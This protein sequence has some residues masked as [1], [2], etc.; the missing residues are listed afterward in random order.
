MQ[1][2]TL[3]QIAI[4][5]EP[6]LT[7]LCLALMALAYLKSNVHFL[8]KTE[9]SMK[10]VEDRRFYLRKLNGEIALLKIQ[11]TIMK[12]KRNFLFQKSN[13]V[14]M[15]HEEKIHFDETILNC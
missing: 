12:C 6:L 9:S 10:L 14:T 13:I 7:V 11:N 8:E 4:I 5:R 3:I 1:V 15:M 2:S